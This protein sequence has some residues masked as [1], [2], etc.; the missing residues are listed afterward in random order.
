M[1]V[2]AMPK[3]DTR[4]TLKWHSPNKIAMQT[5]MAT[6]KFVLIPNDTARATPLLQPGS[7][8]LLSLGSPKLYVW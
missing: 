4:F 5:N 6:R 7:T 1:V 2:K 3:H 8:S